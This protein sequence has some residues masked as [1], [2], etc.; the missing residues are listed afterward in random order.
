MKAVWSGSISFGLVDIP[1]SLYSAVESQ[2]LGF[3]LLCGKCKTPIKYQRYC[4]KCEKEVAWED[5]VKGLEIGRGKYFVVDK[6]TLKELRPEKTESIDLVEFVDA[7]QIDPI[8]FDSHYFAAPERKKEKAY[9]LFKEVLQTMNKVAVGT[10]VMK[11]KEHVCAISAYKKGLLL[12]TLNYAYE[13]RDINDIEVLKSAPK[14]KKEEEKLAKELISKLSEDEFDITQF[15]DTFAEE[16][17]KLL[18]KKAKGEVVKVE[19]EDEAA[20][21]AKPEK[22]LVDALKASL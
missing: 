6:E 5:V 13:I 7:G 14:L 10:F 3:R 8:Y 11:E 17:K 19:E 9:F 4:P 21:Q 12:T 2:S 16:L 18:K 1:V 15:K 22:N 20:K